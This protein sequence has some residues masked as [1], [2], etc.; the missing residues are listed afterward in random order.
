M[1]IMCKRIVL[2]IIG[3]QSVLLCSDPKQTLL[4][5]VKGVDEVA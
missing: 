1:D 4:I 5:K 3:I 2:V